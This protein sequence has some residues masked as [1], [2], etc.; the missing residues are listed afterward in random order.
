M[1][2]GDG[3]FRTDPGPNLTPPIGSIA[4]ADFNHDGKMD[5]VLPPYLFLGNGDGTFRQQGGVNGNFG[6]T[7]VAD[8]NGDGL[9]DLL[10]GGVQLAVL[11][12][13]G[14]STFQ[15]PLYFS[16]RGAFAFT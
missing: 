7:R 3:S 2:K 9:P 15:A 10:I 5:F 8:I 13:N 14:D 1:G 12:N 11:I 4:V 16:A 6:K